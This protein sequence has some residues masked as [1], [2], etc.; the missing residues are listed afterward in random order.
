MAKTPEF[1]GGGGMLQYGRKTR[2]FLKVGFEVLIIV[3]TWFR[4]LFPRASLT[5][6]T[7]SWVL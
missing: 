3:Q 4:A 7:G 6:T 2:V 1:L 5:L